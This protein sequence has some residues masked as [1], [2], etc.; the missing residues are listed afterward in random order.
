VQRNL[1]TV[2]FNALLDLLVGCQIISESSFF[3]KRKDLFW[4]QI[5]LKHSWSQISSNSIRFLSSRTYVPARLQ[6]RYDGMMQL[7]N[8][9]ES[10]GRSQKCNWTSNPGVKCRTKFRY[11]F[12]FIC[13][14]EHYRSMYRCCCSRDTGKQ[15][16][17]INWREKR[18][19]TGSLA[20]SSYAALEGCEFCRQRHQALAAVA[21]GGRPSCRV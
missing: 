11:P 19:A 14:A 13:N 6:P 3:A 5:C 12:P 10:S 9:E 20:S 18:W 2:Q 7:W 8:D 4:I 16:Q 21:P 1:I 15:I 17:G